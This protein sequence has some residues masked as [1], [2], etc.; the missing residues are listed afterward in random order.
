MLFCHF[1]LL[2][3]PNPRSRSLKVSDPCGVTSPVANPQLYNAGSISSIG[4]SQLPFPSG[5]FFLLLV[6]RF[7][8]SF[9][10]YSVHYPN[11]G[12]F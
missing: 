2:T 11:T 6:P 9:F 5:D 1:V 3:P 4:H 8:S 12:F 7:L 10:S